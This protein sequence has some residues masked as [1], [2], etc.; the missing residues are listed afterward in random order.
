M[1]EMKP[2]EPQAAPL[3]APGIRLF[4]MNVPGI[5]KLP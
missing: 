2:I 4:L 1:N 5:E 3:S